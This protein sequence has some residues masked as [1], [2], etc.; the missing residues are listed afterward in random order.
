VILLQVDPASGDEPEIICEGCYEIEG[1]FIFT[2][3]SISNVGHY[4]WLR[5]PIRQLPSNNKVDYLVRT[6]RRILDF[7]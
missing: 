5:G 4:R 1:T 6:I 2:W 3:S 7:M